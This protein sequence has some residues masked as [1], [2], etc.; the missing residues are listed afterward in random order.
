[1]GI[2][3]DKQTVVVITRAE[4]VFLEDRTREAS[5]GTY[6]ISWE[7]ADRDPSIPI[8]TI[9]VEGSHWGKTSMGVPIVG[10]VRLE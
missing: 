7:P 6:A 1:M 3:T 4:G 10:S 8:A 2:P 9:L 5:A